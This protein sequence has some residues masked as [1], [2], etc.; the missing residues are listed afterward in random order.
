MGSNGFW[1]DEWLD[2]EKMLKDFFSNFA[3]TSTVGRAIDETAA[4]AEAPLLHTYSESCWE[5]TEWDKFIYLWL[6]STTDYLNYP[7]LHAPL[8]SGASNIG[9][10]RGKLLMETYVETTP[11]LKSLKE[12]YT[13]V[14]KHLQYAKQSTPDAPERMMLI[15]S[16]LLTAGAWDCNGYPQSDIKYALDYF[17]HLVATVPDGKGLYGVGCYNFNYADEENARWIGKLLR[18]YAV[19]GNKEMLSPRYG[20]VYNGNHVKNPDFKEKTAHWQIFPA[21]KESI[22]PRTIAGYGFRKQRRRGP[23]HGNGD[24]VLEFRRSAKGANKITQT[25]KNFV[26][27]KLYSLSFVTSDADDL[28]KNRNRRSYS[29]LDARLEGAEIIPELSSEFRNPPTEKV[30]RFEVVTRKIVFRAKQKEI[31]AT[32]SDWKDAKT[33]GGPAGARRLLNFISVKSYFAEK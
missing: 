20:I 10:G 13:L 29:F 6:A 15:M 26:P 11:D 21:E 14:S 28:E 4:S 33:P 24:T 25:F 32:F 18:H 5:L 9:F 2:K 7:L 19:E 30:H 22:R 8:I 16:G 31:K 3:G 1:A 12:Y 23:G 17:F 27:G